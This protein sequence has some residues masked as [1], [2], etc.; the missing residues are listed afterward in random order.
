MNPLLVND[1][2]LEPYDAVAKLRELSPLYFCKE[3]NGW[4]VTGYEEITTLFKNPLVV[5]GS[6]TEQVKNQMQGHDISL[7]KDYL[8]LRNKMMLHQDGEEHR[9]MRKPLNKVFLKKQV[10]LLK[11]ILEKS[12]EETLEE[13]KGRE[14]FDF[15]TEFAEPYSTRVIA[16]LFDVPE[17]DRIPFQKASDDVSRF[18]GTTL[19]DVKKDAKIA[20]DSILYL[21][22]YFN[23]LVEKKTQNPGQDLLSFLL[24]Q[25]KFFEITTEEIVAQCIL[26][27]MAGHFTVIDQLCNSM[28]LFQKFH[29]WKDLS[30]E[31]LPLAIEESIR[32][33]GG[34][35][36]MGRVAKEDFNYKNAMIKKGDTLFLGLGAGSHDPKKFEEPEKF[37][38][39][40]NLNGHLSFGHA[41][42]QC[43]GME[44]GRLEIFLAFKALK[45]LYPNL[46]MQDGAKRKA[47]SLFFRGFYHQPV[48]VR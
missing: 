28:A 27:M 25:K 31:N 13:L 8:R 3:L 1:A 20:N 14:E 29:L 35:L 11:P 7:V 48:V 42:H 18:F 40:R 12:L 44:L 41:N 33:D 10:E 2:L 19:G 6:L 4:V 32:M 36:F 22:D 46:K 21:E 37:K 30:K 15:A 26:I 39:D 43:L 45:N 5:A 17:A 38:M 23:K 16:G 24:I 34:V 47:E 9:R